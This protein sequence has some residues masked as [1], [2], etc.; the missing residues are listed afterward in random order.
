LFETAQKTLQE[1]AAAMR[2]IVVKDAD[3]YCQGLE[4]IFKKMMELIGV[5]KSGDA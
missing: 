1:A 5:V 4:K 2:Q 3:E